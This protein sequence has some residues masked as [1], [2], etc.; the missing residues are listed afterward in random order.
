MKR[1]RYRMSY[2]QSLIEVLLAVALT[3]V[4]A[5]G[6]IA[7]QLWMARDARATAI[8]EQAALLAD[9]AAE[10]ASQPE[11]SDAA[12]AQWKARAASLLPQGELTIGGAGPAPSIARAS[13]VAQANAPHNAR[14]D[15]EVIDMPASCGDADVRQGM[16]CIVIA[17]SR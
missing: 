13:W 8:R 5:L 10:L 9:A 2:G 15:G 7:T 12:F 4:T 14:R 1:V 3:G 11:S 6:L 16:A 17:F